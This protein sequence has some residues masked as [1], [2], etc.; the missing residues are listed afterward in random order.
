MD[1]LHVMVTEYMSRGTMYD[2]IRDLTNEY[3][4]LAM[5]NFAMDIARGMLY[6]HER[7]IMQVLLG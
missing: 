1:D 2:F 3:D 4:E 6:L 5:L 7:G